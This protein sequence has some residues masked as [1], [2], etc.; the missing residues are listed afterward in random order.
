[1]I[2]LSYYFSPLQMYLFLTTDF[3]QLSVT[4]QIISLFIAVSLGSFLVILCEN[5]NFLT[6]TE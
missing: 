5:C 4:H 3:I 2:Y 1:M 6:Q